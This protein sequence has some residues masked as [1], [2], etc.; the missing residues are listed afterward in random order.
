MGQH[1]TFFPKSSISNMLAG[2]KTLAFSGG[3]LILNEDCVALICQTLK[4]NTSVVKIIFEDLHLSEKFLKKILESLPEQ[5]F[6]FSFRKINCDSESATT[7]ARFLS[8]H[9]NIFVLDLSH[10]PSDLLDAA[11]ESLAKN[12]NLILETL[13]VDHIEWI[14]TK[15]FKNFMQHNKTIS[16]LIFRENLDSKNLPDFIDVIKNHL[17]VHTLYIDRLSIQDQ[18]LLEKNL[19]DRKMKIYCNFDGNQFDY[20]LSEESLLR[21]TNKNGFL[22]VQEKIL[23]DE[24][25]MHRRNTI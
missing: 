7:F 8:R 11:F 23:A 10:N 6:Y 2:K 22:S 9:N 15:R 12:K 18:F 24:K 20:N 3:N 13:I 14:K 16:T 17:S 25:K 5:A 1:F 21:I 4:T 19:G